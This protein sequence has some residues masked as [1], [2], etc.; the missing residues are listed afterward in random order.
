LR[1]HLLL[2]DSA[3]TDAS[4]KVHALGLG[5]SATVTPTPAQA[6]VALFEIDWHEANE[7]FHFVIQLLDTDGVP[8][9]GP[10]PAGPT[11]LVVE[12]DMEAGRP[13]G[14]P[15]GSHMVLPV[16]VNI[17]PGIALTPGARY[18]WRLDVPNGVHESAYFN[19]YPQAPA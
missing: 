11:P 8:V 19:V 15:Q 18:E 12:G 17:L 5:W 3:Q 9:L 1:A 13:P 7:V 6:L 4:G 16:T 2:A 14:L 10:G